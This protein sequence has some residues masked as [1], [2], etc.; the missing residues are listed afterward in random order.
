MTLKLHAGDIGPVALG[1]VI[2]L[3]VM[4]FQGRIEGFNVEMERSGY[5]LVQHLARRAAQ[6]GGSEWR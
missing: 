3:L 4:F 1:V 5:Q 2:T 6:G